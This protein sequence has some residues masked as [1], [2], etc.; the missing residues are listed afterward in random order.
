MRGKERETEEMVGGGQKTAQAYMG[1]LTRERTHGTRT[2]LSE[3]NTMPGGNHIRISIG[4][5]GE[6]AS[7]LVVR[8]VRGV[9]KHS[10]YAECLGGFCGTACRS[11]SMAAKASKSSRALIRRIG[12]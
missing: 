6:E 11:G 1:I 12:L 4:R 9:D 7:S 5:T 8:M 2:I 3:F 10:G